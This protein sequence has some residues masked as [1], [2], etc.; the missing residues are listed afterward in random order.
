MLRKVISTLNE[1]YSSLAECERK[2]VPDSKTTDYLGN[3]TEHWV[4][5][6]MADFIAR[7]NQTM[8]KLKAID[9]RLDKIKPLDMDK[10][11]KKR[12]KKKL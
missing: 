10:K 1:F 12:R 6:K 11:P 8:Q 9:P 2:L 5:I 7:Y 4:Y 3:S